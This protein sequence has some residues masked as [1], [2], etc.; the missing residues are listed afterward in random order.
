MNQYA[1]IINAAQQYLDSENLEGALVEYRKAHTLKPD[2]GLPAEKIKEIESALENIR[3]QNENYNNAIASADK[4]F[5]EKK[6]EEALLKYQEA[7]RTLPDV[8][9]PKYRITETTSIIEEIQRQKELDSQYELA[10]SNADKFFNE[11]EYNQALDSYRNASLLKPAEQYPK[12][13]ILEIEALMNNIA[14]QEQLQENYDAAITSAD[15]LYNTQNWSEAKIKY[16]EALTYKPAEEHPKARIL[17]ID[18]KLDEIARLKGIDDRYNEAIAQADDLFSKDLYEEARTKYNEASV[19]KSEETYPKQKVE[20]IRT[21]LDALAEQKA[22][23]AEYTQ[24]ITKADEYFEANLLEDART[25]Y[26]DAMVVKPEEQ[27]P[28]DRIAEINLRLE[29][30]AAQKVIDDKYNAA[31][32]LADEAFNK[33]D[34]STALEEYQKAR[35]IKPEEAYP[36]KKIIEINSTLGQLAEEKDRVYNFSISRGDNFLN[37]GK[38]KSAM[39]AYSAAL[40]IKPGESYPQRK[41]SEA[42]SLY[43]AER[44]AKQVEY[45]KAIGDADAFFNDNIYD[46]AIEKY[47]EAIRILPDE[48]YPIDQIAL[49]KKIINDNAIVDVNQNPLLIK[50]NTE[51]KFS[52]NPM[53][54]SVR[55]ENYILIKAKNPV[56]H[57]FK[58]FMNFGQDNTKNGGIAIRIPESSD[59]KEFLIRIGGLYKWF[60][61]DNNWV[62]IYPENGDIEVSLIRISK[63]N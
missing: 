41:H 61:E 38:F 23:D 43:L 56:D 11:K 54:V 53:P 3:V 40:Q 30:I 44:E 31:I 48:N 39:E 19:I 16:Q 14:M 52:F 42:E 58:I 9:Y 13:K 55:K 24:L 57:N 51:K 15:Q 21:L 8:D 32:L 27:Y 45:R 20:E 4:L 18:A 63:S 33:K 29:N 10:I 22:V 50:S 2:E 7:Q 25:K 26:E 62:S 1:D 17:D 6:Y 49:M 37:E 46:R 35:E 12:D 36:G 34:Y 5:E 47:E 28:K 60:S 59:E